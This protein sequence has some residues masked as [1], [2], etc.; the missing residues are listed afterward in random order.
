MIQGL[1]MWWLC[2]LMQCLHTFNTVE[3]EMSVTSSSGRR[4][5]SCSTQHTPENVAVVQSLC[6]EWQQARG[7][8]A[9]SLGTP[10]MPPP[11][12]TC[13]I[14]AV[15]CTSDLFVKQHGSSVFKHVVKCLVMECFEC[16][17]FSIHTLLPTELKLLL[18]S[19]TCRRELHNERAW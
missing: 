18:L 16:E 12:T 14:A 3:E 2:R 1:C 4:L 10:A 15:E 19:V 8:Q 9:C 5:Q 13:F 6:I 17:T 11:T 7:Q